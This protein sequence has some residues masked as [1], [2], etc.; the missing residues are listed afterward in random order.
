MSLVPYS[1]TDS[2]SNMDDNAFEEE[3]CVGKR[4]YKKKLRKIYVQTVLK[5]VSNQILVSSKNVEMTVQ[6]IF[7]KMIGRLFSKIIGA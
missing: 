7:L 1:S 5:N 4:G 2:E 3:T 6:Q